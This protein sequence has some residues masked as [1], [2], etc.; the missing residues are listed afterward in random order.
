[1]ACLESN[2][3][4]ILGR[5]TNGLLKKKL[6]SLRSEFRVYTSDYSKDW[7]R[8]IACRLFG[9]SYQRLYQ[10]LKWAKADLCY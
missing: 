1:M 7:A 8:E 2:Q 3:Y 4:W 10:S 6:R 9:D 5:P